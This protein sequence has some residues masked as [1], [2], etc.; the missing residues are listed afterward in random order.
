MKINVSRKGDYVKKTFLVMMCSKYL[1][2]VCSQLTCRTITFY[3]LLM[4]RNKFLFLRNKKN[5]SFFVD[6]TVTEGNNSNYV[7]CNSVFVG[8]RVDIHTCTQM[9]SAACQ[10]VWQETRP[11]NN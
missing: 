9:T 7:I 3:I 4:K 10:K 6:A 5:R 8:I 11:L 2:N 1:V